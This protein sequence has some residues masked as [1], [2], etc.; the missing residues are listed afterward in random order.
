MRSSA[1]R[2]FKSDSLRPATFAF[3]VT[4]SHEHRKSCRHLLDSLWHQG[5][6]PTGRQSGL[7]MVPFLAFAGAGKTRYSL[8]TER[9]ERGLGRSFAE[10]NVS[11]FAEPALRFFASLRMITEGLSAIRSGA[12]RLRMTSDEW[13]AGVRRPRPPLHDTY[14][15]PVTQTAIRACN[16]SL[17]N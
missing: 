5:V 4:F 3:S 17:R 13:R 15:K 1:P 14:D 8:G 12:N 16:L 10:F 11:I 6:A 2:Q 9:E 7:P